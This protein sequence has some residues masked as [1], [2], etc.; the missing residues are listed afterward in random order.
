V[1][2]VRKFS[3]DQLSSATGKFS[4]DNK[5]GSGSFGDVYK[6]SLPGLG[7]LAV[8]RIVRVN[9]RAIRDY[10]NEINTASQLDHPNVLCFMGSCNENNRQ[11]LLVY[12][13]MQNRSL[14]YHLHGTPNIKLDWNK[15]YVPFSRLI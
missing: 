4:D 3:Y 13:L 9:D 12:E 7:Y 2:L 1:R 6:G 14:D 5:L 15:R 8:K 10:N 11:L